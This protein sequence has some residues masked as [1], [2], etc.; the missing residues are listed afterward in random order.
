[1]NKI[2]KYN[3][4]LPENKPSPVS[5]STFEIASLIN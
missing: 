1:M 4:V 2:E 5:L 3:I